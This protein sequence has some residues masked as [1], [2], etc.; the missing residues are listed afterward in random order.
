MAQITEFVSNNLFLFIALL[1]VIVL[2][3]KEEFAHQT[4]KAIQLSPAQATRLMNNNDNMLI[5]D[6]RSSDEFAKGHIKNAMNIP[7]AELKNSLDKVKKFSERPALIY[8]NSGSTSLKAARILQ[9]GGFNA[10]N[11][12]VGGILAWKEAGLPLTRK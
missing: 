2:L 1:A 10:V 12:L 6:I 5:L 9:A 3:I 8:C 4:S 11:H 7:L